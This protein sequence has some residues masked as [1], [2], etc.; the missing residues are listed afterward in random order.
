MKFDQNQFGVIDAVSESIQTAG[1]INDLAERHQIEMPLC[2]AVYGI[3]YEGFSCVST[4]QELLKRDVPDQEI[5]IPNS[6]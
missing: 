2:R 6:T 3:I 1:S 4:L 5:R